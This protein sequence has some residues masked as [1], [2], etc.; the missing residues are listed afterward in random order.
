MNKEILQAIA[1]KKVVAFIYQ[2]YI[3]IAE[4]HIYGFFRGSDRLIVWQI[5]GGPS[6]AQLPSWLSVAVPQISEFQV[7]DETFSGK[8]ADSASHHLQW[9]AT[10]AMVR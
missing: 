2:N 9:D 1:G 6:S 7:L 4:P 5:R 3:R 8:R 10:F